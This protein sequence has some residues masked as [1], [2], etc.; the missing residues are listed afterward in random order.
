VLFFFQIYGDF[1][2]YSDIAIGTAKLFGFKLSKNFNIPYLAKSVTAFWQ[3]WHITL[4]RW[5]TD[6][7][8]F[9]IIQKNLRSNTRRNLA[10]FLTMGLIGL[11]HGADWTFVIFGVFQG[12]LI[13]FE[14]TPLT[15]DRKSTLY[16]KALIPNFMVPVLSFI[17]IT[18]SCLLF[19]S[20]NIDELWVILKRILSFIPSESIGSLIDKRFLI[21][22]FI[23][24]T[25][26]V[27]TRFKDFPLIQL[28]R[29]INRPMRWIL[30]YIFIFLIFRY[31]GPKE[32]FIY[33]Q[34]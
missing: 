14:R 31:A 17:F 20:R 30:Y 12:L 18:L 23:M 33:F 2:G 29:Y 21:F 19:R 4:T 10:I 13:I 3:R 8:Y 27:L 32:D 15:K 16:H 7:V 22:V 9:P 26:E 6:Y 28:D 25:F 1:S 34:F 11:W 24:I 5:F